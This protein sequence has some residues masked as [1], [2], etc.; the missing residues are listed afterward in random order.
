MPAP[1]ATA[2]SATTGFRASEDRAASTGGEA[3]YPPQAAGQAF[4]PV[5]V[6]EETSRLVHVLVRRLRLAAPGADLERQGVPFL[7][8]VSGEDPH[9]DPACCSR[10]SVAPAAV[11]A[12]AARISAAPV[13]G[14]AA[15]RF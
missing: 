14:A 3:G 8:S 5:G 15:A 12:V 9:T 13:G 2:T 7:V 4:A 6:A 10:S 1:L 11:A